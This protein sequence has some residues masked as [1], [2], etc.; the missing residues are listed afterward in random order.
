MK[1]YVGNI[2]RHLS[3]DQF[4]ALASPFGK[5]DSVSVPRDSASG[6][7]QGYGFLEFANSKDALAV[8]AGLN[9]KDIDGQILN[10]SEVN[11]AR[12]IRRM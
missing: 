8:I 11:L 3:D 9:G 5:A 4:R 2:S 1:V 6:K 7:T 12:G 10:A